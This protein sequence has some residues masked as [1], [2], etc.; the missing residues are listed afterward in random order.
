MR[1]IILTLIFFSIWIYC[2]SQNCKCPDNGFSSS[3]DKPIIEIG[4]ENNKLIVCG[5]SNVD[6]DNGYKSG[7]LQKDSSI[8][9]CGFEVFL[10]KDTVHP[11]I[12]F[13]EIKIFKLKE[14]K[15]YLTL[16]LMM[17]LPIVK[18]LNYKNTS[19]I[20]YKISKHKSTWAIEKPIIILD[21]SALT[22]NDFFK[23]KKDLGWDK[24]YPE[25]MFKRDVNYEEN[26]IVYAFILCL[27]EFPKYNQE[28]NN[29]GKYDGYL[30]EIHN[31]FEKILMDIK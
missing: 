17:N 5:Y 14:Y 3:K 28:F 23:I 1:H 7:I 4:N 30:A 10:Y 2:Y 31:E 25:Q 6:L 27:K 16:D 15:D 13:G 8:Y 21:F 11:L 22:E 18:D 9:L 26:K 19:L 29:M 12:R 20:R 24:L